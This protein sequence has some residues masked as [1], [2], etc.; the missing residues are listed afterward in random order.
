V[1]WLQSGGTGTFPTAV[2]F[3][4]QVTTDATLPPVFEIS[5]LLGIQRLETLISPY[6]KDQFGV[7]TYPSAQNVATLMTA[8]TG[9]AQNISAFA[10]DFT[11]A[12]NTQKLAL[13]MNDTATAPAEQLSSTARM[14]KQLKSLKL[15]SDGSG[16]ARANSN[17]IW[18]AAASLLDISIGTAANSGPRFLSPKPLDNTLN[19]AMVP[20]PALPAG[21]PQLPSQRLFVD[22]DLDQLNRTFFQA[23]DDLLTPASAAQAFEQAQNAYTTTAL[24]RESL[25]QKYALYEVDWLFDAQSHFTGTGD[26]LAIAQEVFE[27]QMRAALMTAYSVDTIVQYDVTWN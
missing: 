9:G 27:Q 15:A 4:T 6:L 18:A 11:T 12:F 8:A 20:L 22:V 24:G 10:K 17:S 1:K 5:V 23:V 16:G 25:A 19:S 3:P 26:Q 13:G 21:L 14:R 7:I 2:R